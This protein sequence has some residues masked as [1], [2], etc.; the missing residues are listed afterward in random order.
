MQVTIFMWL[1]RTI[2]LVSFGLGSYKQEGAN[3]TETNIYN[4]GSLDTAADF[5]LTVAKTDKGY[6]QKS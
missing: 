6:T 5:K 2:P 3:I 4:T 1:C